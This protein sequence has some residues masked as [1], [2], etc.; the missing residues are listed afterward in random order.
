[1][2]LNNLEPIDQKKTNIMRS[3][4]KLLSEEKK[5]QMKRNTFNLSFLGF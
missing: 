3:R 2:T 5:R 4:K 1:M